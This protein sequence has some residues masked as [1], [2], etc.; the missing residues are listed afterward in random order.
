MMISSADGHPG[1]PLAITAEAKPRELACRS[2]GARK[3]NRQG[4]KDA[5]VGEENYRRAFRGRE[6][7]PGGGWG[8]QPENSP[9]F[10]YAQGRLFAPRGPSPRLQRDRLEIE[11]V[12]G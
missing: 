1:V 10:G 11:G 6:P 3:S 9:P 5:K 8:R 2:P 4:A 7:P 12:G